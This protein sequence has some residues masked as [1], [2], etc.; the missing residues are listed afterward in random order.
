MCSGDC[1]RFPLY[2]FGRS[3][4]RVPRTSTHAA[5]VIDVELSLVGAIYGG[6]AL[7]FTAY[8]QILISQKQDEL[9]LTG[10]QLAESVSA[11]MALLAFAFAYAIDPAFVEDTAAYFAAP[12]WEVTPEVLLIVSSSLMALS[13]NIFNWSLIGRTS[14]VTFQVVGNAKTVFTLLFGLILV[15]SSVPFTRLLK[16]VFGLAVAVVGVCVYGDVKLAATEKRRDVLDRVL[17]VCIRPDV[18]ARE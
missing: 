12:Q 16:H 5:T 6:L 9:G 17:P 11:Y 2:R 14:P 3:R 18:C 10:A 8:C 13:V 1:V 15:P 4:P 7:L